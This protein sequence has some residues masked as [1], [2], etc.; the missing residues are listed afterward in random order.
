MTSQPEPTAPAP[1]PALIANSRR[2]WTDLAFQMGALLA[3]FLL[4]AI[5]ALLT[6]TFLTTS[7]L[8]G[9]A[10]QTSVNALLS[11][12]MLVVILTGGI[13]L[14]VGAMLA[15]AMCVLAMV[16][17]NLGMDQW[18]GLFAALLVGA[19]LGAVNGLMLT[20]LHLPHPFISTL[21]MMNIARGVALVITGAAPISALGFG[22]VKLI[23][24]DDLKLGSGDGAV[25]IPY[26]VFV[27]ILAY[28]GFWFFLNRTVV[29]RHIYA[30]GGNPEA[31]RLSGVPVSRILVLVYTISGVMAGL[32]AAVLA[33]RTDSGYPNA[34]LGFELDA[35][36]A[37]IIGGTSFFG[38]VGGVSGTL[39]GALIMAVLR[40]GL[41]LKAVDTNYQTIVIGAVIIAAVYVD[42]LRRR[43]GES[44]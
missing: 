44:R 27:V 5:L 41:N 31:A 23:G 3:L 6:P 9:V 26:M 20:K 29:G 43:A 4:C 35:I 40:N 38:G 21:G 36:S 16:V 17:K 30:T 33:G 39:I 22:I 7:N 2:N 42:V 34:G 12:G 13:D 28:V 11:L 37:C 32:A 1:A 19:G 8:A 18:F 15:L 24:N 14:S 10:R 25:A